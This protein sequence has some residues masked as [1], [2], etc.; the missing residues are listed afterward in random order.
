MVQ[1]LTLAVAL[2][3]VGAQAPTAAPDPSLVRVFV[4]TDDMGEP[5][6][7]AARRESVRD[8]SAALA[9]RK[10]SLVIV[11]TRNAADVVLDVLDRGVTVPK[12]VIG[13]GAR[14]GDPTT[15]P[16]MAQ[17]AR[18][19]VLRVA[20]TA[21]AEPMI[22]TNKNKPNDSSRGW[23][24]AADDVVNQVDKWVKARREEIIKRRD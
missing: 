21:G 10:K 13:L 24:S 22:F 12:V 16:G 18:Q 3:G 14:S 17:P 7:L 4:R 8:L 9:S 19:A 23:K 2:L 5:R 15:I 6:E 20:M 11:Y 1:V